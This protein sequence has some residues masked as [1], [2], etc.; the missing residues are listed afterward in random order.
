MEKSIVKPD[1]SVIAFALASPKE[2]IKRINFYDIAFVEWLVE[3]GF[4]PS[5]YIALFRGITCEEFEGT[6]AEKICKGCGE[7]KTFGISSKTG[8]YEW[9]KDYTFLCPTCSKIDQAEKREASLRRTK[10]EIEE[11]EQAKR[12]MEAILN[13]GSKWKPDIKKSKRFWIASNL[14]NGFPDESMEIVT[15]MSYEEFLQTP[16][17]KAVAYKVKQGAGFK[18][19]IC[20]SGGRLQTHHR[21]YDNHGLEHTHDGMKDLICV[22]SSCHENHHFGRDK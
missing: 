15:S 20:G 16:Y 14:V 13:P 12:R 10:E 4:S 8:L 2:H 6:Q 17:W 7:R 18:C 21:S 3:S 19:Q 9:M 22:C 5:M 1:R 11:K